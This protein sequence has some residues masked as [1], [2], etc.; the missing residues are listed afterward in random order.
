MCQPFSWKIDA[1]LRFFLLRLHHADAHV[2]NLSCDLPTNPLATR[3]KENRNHALETGG[4][5]TLI[6]NS[7]TSQDL[8]STARK[9]TGNMN[10]A[11]KAARHMED[12]R[13][14]AEPPKPPPYPPVDRPMVHP[15]GYISRRPENISRT[16][17][18]H[19][20]SAS[21]KGSLPRHRDQEL[22]RRR[23]GHVRRRERS[24]EDDD[25]SASSDD[26][27]S[28]RAP[29]HSPRRD[30][31]PN[32]NNKPEP[33]FGSTRKKT[34]GPG[35]DPSARRKQLDEHFKQPQKSDLVKT[36]EGA[37]TPLRVGILLGC[38]DLVGGTL[39]IWMTK[40]RNAKEKEAEAEKLALAAQAAEGAGEEPVAPR[41]GERREKYGNDR[42]YGSSNDSHDSRRRNDRYR[43]R[44]SSDLEPDSDSEDFDVPPSIGGRQYGRRHTHASR[45]RR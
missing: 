33:S 15:G 10:G 5:F 14:F 13:P 39:T 22:Q 40:R 31:R 30:P 23:A 42:R 28:Q 25:D 32:K 45:S 4:E 19:G 21:S 24:P 38:F 2:L 18:D 11:V 6:L 20:S 12:F 29:R 34:A 37:I 17:I 8:R 16:T 1:S 44:Y 35:D 26:D 3:D 27:E 9:T 36:L 41:G 43:R 7:R